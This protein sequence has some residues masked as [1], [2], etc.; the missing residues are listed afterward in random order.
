MTA[1]HHPAVHQRSAVRRPLRIAGVCAAFTLIELLVVVCIIAV[2]MSLLMT[3]VGSV[4]NSARQVQCASNLRQ[5]GV[6]VLSHLV[7]EKRLPPPVASCNWPF[8]NL[9]Y[10]GGWGSTPTAA[11]AMFVDGWIES[12][13]VFYCP[14][15]STVTEWWWNMENPST[16]AQ[17]Q[18]PSNFWY[19]YIGYAWW[20][21]YQRGDVPGIARNRWSPADSVLASDLS[22]PA[23]SYMGG[24][25]VTDSGE[26]RG[27]NTLTM[28]GRVSWK[29]F[30]DMTWR[31]NYYMDFYF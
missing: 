20:A 30:S 17:Q 23:H 2:L 22:F 16:T 24:N 7:D 5:I 28:D 19:C 27:G 10:N 15:A 1:A 29:R 8:G 9:T 12:P 4:R 11:A 26:C 31:M 13:R 3:V 14:Q 21:N 18:T 6:L 25:H